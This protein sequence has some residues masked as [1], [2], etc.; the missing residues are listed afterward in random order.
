MYARTNRCYNERGSRT[1]YVRSTIP[2]CILLVPCY[3]VLFLG[4]VFQMSQIVLFLCSILSV[5]KQKR[6]FFISES[7]N[8]FTAN[9]KTA[10][11]DQKLSLPHSV[12]L[13]SFKNNFDAICVQYVHTRHERMLEEVLRHRA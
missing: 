5:F 11:L 13:C 8:L 9:Y 4:N 3:A 7:R 12:F 10:V 6:L 1:N 2:Q